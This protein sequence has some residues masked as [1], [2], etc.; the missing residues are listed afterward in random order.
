MIKP[1]KF[2]LEGYVSSLNGGIHNTTLFVVFKEKTYI[3]EY[4]KYK[5]TFEEIIE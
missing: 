3:E 1:R 2:E 4:N 5:I